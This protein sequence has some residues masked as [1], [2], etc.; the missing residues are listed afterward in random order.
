MEPCGKCRF[1]IKGENYDRRMSRGPKED[2]MIGECHR[3]PPIEV[4]G[5][6]TSMWPHVTVSTAGCGEFK[7]NAA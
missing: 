6:V 1:F 7:K 4:A 2:H 5:E 3:N